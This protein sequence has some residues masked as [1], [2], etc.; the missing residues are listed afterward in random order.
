MDDDPT[1]SLTGLSALLTGHRPISET[2]TAIAQVA[3]NAIP[4][5]GRCRPDD[6]R[7]GPAPDRAFDKLRVL[8]QTQHVKV[9]DV[10]RV[11]VDDAVHRAR[12]R[13]PTRLLTPGST[14]E[15]G[16]GADVRAARHRSARAPE[17]RP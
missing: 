15:L 12:R 11:I 6:A 8:S 17:Y 14:A 1:V 13:R 16:S 3:V 10:C 2:L 9:A 7:A 4:G 5:G